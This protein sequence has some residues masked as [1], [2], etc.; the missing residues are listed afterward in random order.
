MEELNKLNRE[1]IR[2]WFI[3]KYDWECYKQ[4]EKEFYI[5]KYG[6]PFEKL[7]IWR[8]LFHSIME[9]DRQWLIKRTEEILEE[10]WKEKASPD[11]SKD[12]END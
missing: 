9:E 10:K 6:K 5:N 8:K 12:I 4:A 2:D 1:R 3:E 11:S 7:P